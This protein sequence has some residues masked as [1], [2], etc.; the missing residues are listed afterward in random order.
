MQLGRQDGRDRRRRVSGG[1]PRRVFRLALPRQPDE[2]R[3]IGHGPYL[4]TA[5]DATALTNGYLI[6]L[7]GT[8]LGQVDVTTAAVV[9]LRTTPVV[10]RSAAHSVNRTLK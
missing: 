10:R 9:L 2:R 7:D 1:E 4:H 8:T 3:P 5:A 6:T